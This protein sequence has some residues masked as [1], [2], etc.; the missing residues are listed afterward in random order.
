MQAMPI[1]HFPLI[2]S[3]N[4]CRMLILLTRRAFFQSFSQKGWIICPSKHKILTIRAFPAHSMSNLTILCYF[5][6][7]KVVL[8]C[9]SSTFDVKSHCFVELFLKV[10]N[11]IG[12]RLIKSKLICKHF[13]HN[14]W[15]HL[16]KRWI[17][18]APQGN[19]GVWGLIPSCFVS[20]L[21]EILIKIKEFPRALHSPPK[22][23]SRPHDHWH[24][25]D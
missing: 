17:F 5:L 12:N 21:K 19:K 14:L 16:S 11:K 6:P 24:M 2:I 22:L 7:K 4:P 18:L 1:G 3:P 13:T 25:C 20:F 15:L 23:S 10:Y 9:I 8:A